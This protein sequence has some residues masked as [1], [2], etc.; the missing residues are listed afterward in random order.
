MKYEINDSIIPLDPSF[1]DV[2]CINCYECIKF[3]DMD[4]HSQNCIIELDYFKDNSYDED[5]NARIFKLHESLKSKKEEIENKNDKNL[6]GFYNHLLKIIYQII[7]NNN[8]I[9]ELDN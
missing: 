6:I 3:E 8:S 9:E 4:L 7:I 2:L 1:L 5:Y